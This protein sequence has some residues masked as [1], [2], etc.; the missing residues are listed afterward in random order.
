MLHTVPWAVQWSWLVICFM[1]VT[2]Y[3]LIPGDAVTW[4]P[5]ALVPLR[6]PP[7]TASLFLSCLTPCSWLSSFL[8]P[9]L[10]TDYSLRMP[11]SGAAQGGPGGRGRQQSPRHSPV[12]AP[13]PSRT[14]GP[15]ASRSDLPA[16]LGNPSRCLGTGPGAFPS[17]PGLSQSGTWGLLDR[18]SSAGAGDAR[19][20]GCRNEGLSQKKLGQC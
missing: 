19:G 9:S 14:T 3:L 17:P 13:A 11:A 18:V 16:G 2:M 4:G 20:R 5:K 7:G 10:W 12:G 6:W 8:I 1:H 15:T